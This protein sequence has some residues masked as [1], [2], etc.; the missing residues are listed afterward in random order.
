VTT[1]AKALFRAKISAPDDRG[2]E[3]WLGCIGGGGYGHVRWGGKVVSAH[4][5]AFFLANGSWPT[6]HVLH[7]CDNPICCNPAHLSDGTHQQ[8]MAECAARNRNR[9][10]RPGNGRPKLSSLDIALIRRRFASG[11]TNKSALAREF[12]VTAP[13]IRQVLK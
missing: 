8:N 10:P 11:E 1:S 13:R 2:C 3:N 9:S 4:R 12:G 6:A 7:A 5:V